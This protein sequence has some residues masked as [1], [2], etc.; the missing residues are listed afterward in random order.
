MTLAGQLGIVAPKVPLNDFEGLNHLLL[1]LL[2]KLHRIQ[3]RLTEHH[4][5]ANWLTD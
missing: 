3:V 4:L 1:D 2:H 5:D